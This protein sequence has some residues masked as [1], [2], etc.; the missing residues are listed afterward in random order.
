[1]A[2]YKYAYYYYKYNSNKVVA[3]KQHYIK[4]NIKKPKNVKKC[5][6][7]SKVN[8]WSSL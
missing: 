8:R 3:A 4:F 1:M 2:L 7:T 5:V 6:K